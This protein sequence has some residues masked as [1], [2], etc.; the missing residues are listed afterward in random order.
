LKIEL[1]RKCSK[2]KG[3]INRLKDDI[4]IKDKLEVTLRPDLRPVC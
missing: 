3:K 1:D 2:L 4:F